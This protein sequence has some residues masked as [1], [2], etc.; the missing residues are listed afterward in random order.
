MGN[1]LA[2]AGADFAEVGK[3]DPFFAELDA[4]CRKHNNLWNAEAE[5]MLLA[6]FGVK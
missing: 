2:R 6:H 5:K 4:V 1:D 3:K